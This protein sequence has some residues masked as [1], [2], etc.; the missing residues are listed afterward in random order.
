MEM[1]YT[2]DMPSVQAPEAARFRLL[3]F[4]KKGDNFIYCQHIIY[5]IEGKQHSI[6]KKFTDL[7]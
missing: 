6:R 5:I 1:Q 3:S 4:N 2:R 7:K